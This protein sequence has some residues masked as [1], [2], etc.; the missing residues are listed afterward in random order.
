MYALQLASRF[1]CFESS[2]LSVLCVVCCVLGSVGLMVFRCVVRFRTP[3]N[4]NLMYLAFYTEHI[5]QL[6]VSLFG[7]SVVEETPNK[8]TKRWKM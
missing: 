1:G 4:R 5:L 8:R 7:V 3:H 6:F 2:A